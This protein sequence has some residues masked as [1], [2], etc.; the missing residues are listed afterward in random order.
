MLVSATWSVVN[1]LRDPVETRRGD[2]LWRD[3][4][5]E[6]FSSGEAELLEHQG[7]IPLLPTLL[8]STVRYSVED[9]AVKADRPAGRK[10]F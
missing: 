3:P 1:V 5:D 10:G 9:Q 6:A 4:T 7:L 2:D 8:H